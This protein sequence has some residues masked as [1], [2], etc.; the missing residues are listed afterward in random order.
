MSMPHIATLT[1]SFDPAF[2]F[3]RSSCHIPSDRTSQ[4]PADLPTSS[5]SSFSSSCARQQHKSV[6]KDKVQVLMIVLY[7]T[8]DTTSMNAFRKK[9]RRTTSTSRIMTHPQRSRLTCRN[10]GSCMVRKLQAFSTASRSAR[11]SEVRGRTDRVLLDGPSLTSSPHGLGL[12]HQSFHIP[13]TPAP[14]R[15]VAL[16]VWLG[17]GSIQ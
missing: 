16:D 5:A 17:C 14:L 15:T 4:N 7:H 3:S 1:Y 2:P 8:H 9:S 6:G 11:S 13:N 12:R 10:G